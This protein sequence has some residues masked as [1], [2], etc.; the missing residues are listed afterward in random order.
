MNETS[1]LNKV[2]IKICSTKN[3]IEQYF[4]N[5]KDP[6]LDDIKTISFI[7]KYGICLRG[8]SI[9]TNILEN[10]SNSFGIDLD[11][12]SIIEDLALINGLNRGYLTEYQLLVSF[13]SKLYVSDDRFSNLYRTI[14][15]KEMLDY[16]ENKKNEYIQNIKRYFNVSKK[17]LIDDMNKP[18]SFLKYAEQTKNK[19]PSE[20]ILDVLGE[21]FNLMR[22][23]FGLNIHPSYYSNNVYETIKSFRMQFVYT[24]ID[25]LDKGLLSTNS[26]NLKYSLYNEYKRI[27]LA[28]E[29]KDKIISIKKV[30]EDTFSNTNIVDDWIIYTYSRIKE[31]LVD[32]LLSGNLISWD[33]AS[34]KLKVLYEYCSISYH[35]NKTQTQNIWK[36]ISDYRVIELLNYNNFLDDKAFQDDITRSIQE[37]H[38]T[39][40]E[41]NSSLANDWRVN[42]LFFLY[43]HK[44]SFGKMV[45]DF[46]Y[47]S[48][49]KA[50]ANLSVALY[51]KAL[52]ENHIS[53]NII[54]FDF[55]LQNSKQKKIV[56]TYA[57]APIYNSY[58]II[59]G[60]ANVNEQNYVFF[61]YLKYLIKGDI[62]FEFFCDFTNSKNIYN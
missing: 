22:E 37:K 20:F 44:L 40:F 25:V 3:Q 56:I 16:F 49:P 5:S 48:V 34:L 14:M 13:F 4:K 7:I 39:N 27:Y 26:N 43:G 36:K 32:I 10:N 18:Y 8:L 42:Q 58:Y 1:Y 61:S 6:N 46:F 11:A 47:D 9:I 45:R 28:N 38:K 50:A 35:I 54:P 23:F 59:L 62:D 15:T 30:F 19:K 51:K 55:I 12:R 57:C 60:D 33:F 29:D 52:N 31:L 24:I 2:F 17:E 53:F 41:N 21:D